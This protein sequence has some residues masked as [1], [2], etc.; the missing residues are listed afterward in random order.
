MDQARN[1]L[2]FLLAA[3]AVAGLHAVIVWMLLTRMG[4][5]RQPPV[6]RG[7][8]LFWLPPP[9]RPPET[10]TNAVPPAPS[11]RIPQVSMP[12]PAVP[13]VPPGIALPPEVAEP[14]PEENNAIHPPI[15]WDGELSRAAK[16]AVSA[17]ADKHYREFDFPRPPPALEKPAEFAWYH[18]VES[19][20]GVLLVHLGNNCALVFFPLPFVGCSIGHKPANGD[21]FKGMK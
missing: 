1:R 17:Q 5:L 2:R 19:Q 13:D 11:S 6:P 16:N 4:V 8:E 14:T 9:T 10:V 21:L 20:G 12:S 7:L 3:M 15:D 18:R